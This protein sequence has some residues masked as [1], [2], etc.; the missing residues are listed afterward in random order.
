VF[1]GFPQ[2]KKNFFFTLSGQTRRRKSQNNAFLS[3]AGSLAPVE[4]LSNSRELAFVELGKTRSREPGVVAGSC[5]PINFAP[6]TN[7]KDPHK[8]PT[9][10]KDSVVTNPYPPITFGPG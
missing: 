6:M 1:G 7:P 9:V 4:A 5:S 8:F 2:G 3:A 10:V